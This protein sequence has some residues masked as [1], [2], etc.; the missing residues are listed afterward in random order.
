M[1][2]KAAWANE[3]SPAIPVITVTDRNT[4]DRITAWVT[5]S[6]QKASATDR[7][8]HRPTPAATAAT[9]QVA[10]VSS[11]LRTPAA[12]AGGGGSKP[13]RGSGILGR[14]A[15]PGPRAGGRERG[16]NG[17]EGRNPRARELPA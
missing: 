4:M 8:H 10:T 17:E 14:R 5:S 3:I 11:R 1:A 6:S 9:I 2:A 16:T 7:A 13:A 15:S 12:R